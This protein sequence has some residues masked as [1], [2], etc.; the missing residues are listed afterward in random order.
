MIKKNFKYLLVYITPI[1]IITSIYLSGLW[2]YLTLVYVFMMIPTVEL[3]F[4]GTSKNM[5]ALDEEAAVKDT[6]YDYI[7]YSLVPI[8][9]GIFIYFLFRVAD[10]LP[11]KKEKIGKQIMEKIN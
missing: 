11:K 8:Q 3:L 7:L 6:F 1:I 9:I 10:P 4:K 5:N 2:T